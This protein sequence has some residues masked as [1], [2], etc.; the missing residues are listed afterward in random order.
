MVCYC[1]QALYLRNYYLSPHLGYLSRANNVLKVTALKECN[2]GLI[3]SY[4]IEVV[5]IRS[6][7]LDRSN[8]D[9]SFAKECEPSFQCNENTQRDV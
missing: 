4:F 5:K 8:V 1:Y 9:K 6:G 3:L 2:I 7:L